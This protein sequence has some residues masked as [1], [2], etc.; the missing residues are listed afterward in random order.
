MNSMIDTVHNVIGQIKRGGGVM[1]E[2]R[3]GGRAGRRSRAGREEQRKRGKSRAE[4]RSRTEQWMKGGEGRGE[5]RRRGQ[6]RGGEEVT[7]WQ[8]DLEN[9]VAEE[10]ICKHSHEM[11]ILGS[12]LD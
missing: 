3:A 11:E 4:Q 2:G 1:G 10:P 7:M 6:R 9:L 8:R 5:Q 12:R